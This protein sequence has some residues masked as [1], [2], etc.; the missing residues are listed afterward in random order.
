MDR[1]SPVELR[2]SLSLSKILIDGGIAFIPIPFT[3]LTQKEILLKQS[4]EQLKA[5]EDEVTK[6]WLTGDKK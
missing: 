3:N 1:A 4:K 2:N 6:E 5:I